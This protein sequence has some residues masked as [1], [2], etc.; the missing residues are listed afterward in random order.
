M[1]K[2]YVSLRCISFLTT[3]VYSDVSLVLVT[4][5]TRSH[6]MD[7]KYLL[8]DAYLAYPETKRMLT[9]VPGCIYPLFRWVQLV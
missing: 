3:T 2:I 6:Y 9:P 8:P 4:L 1:H 7:V 5:V